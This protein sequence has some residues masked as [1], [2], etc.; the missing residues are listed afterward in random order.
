MFAERKPLVDRVLAGETVRL[1]ATMKF[2]TAR[3]S[4]RWL[5]YTYVPD[6]APDGAVAGFFVFAVDLTERHAAEQRLERREDDLRRVM[7]S[8]PAFVSRIGRDGRY[9]YMN[10]RYREFL[11]PKADNAIGMRFAEIL[12]E[13]AFES[14]QGYFARALAGETVPFEATLRDQSGRERVMSQVYT[15]EID[16]DG[17]VRSIFVFALDTTQQRDMDERVRG[18]ERNLRILNDSVP[19]AICRLDRELRF[20]Y[21][22]AFMRG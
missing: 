21:V 11:G 20:Q 18:A 17:V 12:G 10:G 9:L 16:S 3:E 2:P 14:R 5:A 8:L 6:C 19:L 1:E 13:P 15:P 22:N 7:D 4:E